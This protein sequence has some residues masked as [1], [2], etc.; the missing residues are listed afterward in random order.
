MYTYICI[1]FF[2]IIKLIEKYIEN[3]IYEVDYEVAKYDFR[4]N[5]RCYLMKMSRGRAIYVICIAVTSY[6]T[7]S[8]LFWFSVT[9]RSI[10]LYRR[11]CF[12]EWFIQ[13]AAFMPFFVQRGCATLHSF[14]IIYE[15][16][17]KY[18][19]VRTYLCARGDIRENFL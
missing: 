16:L 14:I 2:C 11:L 1:L 6:I 3:R 12:L 13:G 10:R 5:I 4:D 8:A 17:N 9:S 19:C 15:Y 18:A 7:C